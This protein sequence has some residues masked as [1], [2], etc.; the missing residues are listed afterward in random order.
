MC[1][2][3]RVLKQ[4]MSADFGHY[5]VDSKQDILGDSDGD[6]SS[7]ALTRNGV[8]GSNGCD[9]SSGDDGETHFA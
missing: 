2:A 4:R 6:R 5:S 8:L 1:P 3:G 7:A 9:E